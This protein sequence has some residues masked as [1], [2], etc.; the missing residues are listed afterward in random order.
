MWGTQEY[1]TQI[2][3]F[4]AIGIQHHRSPRDNMWLDCDKRNTHPGTKKLCVAAS[5]RIGVGDMQ[6]NLPISGPWLANG[7]LRRNSALRHAFFDLYDALSILEM[8]YKNQDFQL[9]WKKLKGAPWH[10][11][12]IFL[13][14]TSKLELSGRCPF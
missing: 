9:P 6:C 2:Q 1:N 4:T 13:H 11:W 3:S 5:L 10:H 8:S 14:G 12:P 7:W